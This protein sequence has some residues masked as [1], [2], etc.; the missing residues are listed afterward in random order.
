MTLE[1]WVESWLSKA[2]PNDPARG[3][4]AALLDER[5]ELAEKGA[6]YDRLVV[7]LQV[8]KYDLQDACDAILRALPAGI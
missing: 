3:L 1:E 5:H 4:V 6:K 7:S 2:D 8:A